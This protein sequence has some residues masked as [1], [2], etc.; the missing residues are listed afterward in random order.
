MVATRLPNGN[1]KKPVTKSGDGGFR[2]LRVLR[3]KGDILMAMPLGHFRSEILQPN[4]ADLNDGYGP[5]HSGFNAV[6]AV[7]AY[8]SHIFHDLENSGRD[9]FKEI[10]VEQP[11]NNDD[12]AFR[13]ALAK[14]CPDF[15]LLRDT[16]KANKHAKLTQHSPVVNGSG[17]TEIQSVGFGKGKYGLG[18][19]G[20]LSQITVTDVK[21]H[22]HNL[23]S[24]VKA[25][26]HFLDGIAG[27]L[28]LL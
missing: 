12:G 23:W 10:G 13:Y 28:G 19:Y 4:L 22:D 17:D 18:S 9:P 11:K 24:A 6:A 8:A 15:E 3:R 26:V 5:L 27:D 16:A 25:S 14:K 1:Q 7:D 21:G 2:V 20:S